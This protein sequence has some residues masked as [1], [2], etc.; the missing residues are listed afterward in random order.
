MMLNKVYYNAEMI[1]RVSN[2]PSKDRQWWLLDNH[3]CFTG[4]CSRCGYQ[5]SPS[6]Q[7]NWNCPECGCVYDK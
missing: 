6:N 3:P 1:K 4:K 5:F 7:N 2:K